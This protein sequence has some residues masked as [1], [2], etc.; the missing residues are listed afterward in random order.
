L[1]LTAKGRNQFEK[2]DLASHNQVKEILSHLP[3]EKHDE[4]IFHMNAIKKILHDKI[5]SGK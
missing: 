4:L 5:N 2:L 1:S 3:K